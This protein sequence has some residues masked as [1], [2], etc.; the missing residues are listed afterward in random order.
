MLGPV[1]DAVE[2][3]RIDALVSSRVAAGARLAAGG[4]HEGLFYRP[5]VLAGLRADTPAGRV[6]RGRGAQ[7][8]AADARLT[9]PRT[10]R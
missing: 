6:L 10:A 7:A 4:T 5:T 1:I 3:E 2:V 8:G 9:P